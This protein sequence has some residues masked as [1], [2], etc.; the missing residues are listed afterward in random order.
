MN[1]GN[2]AAVD[3]LKK[4][5]KKSTVVFSLKPSKNS[6]ADSVQAYSCNSCRNALKKS[7]PLM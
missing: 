2:R 3:F 4:T 7:E 1:M 5:T 6:A